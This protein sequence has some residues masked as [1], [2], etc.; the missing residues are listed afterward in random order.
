MIKL[1]ITGGIGSGKS[2]VSR[3]LQLMG[4]PVYFTDD[5]AKRLNV[6]SPVIRQGLRALVGEKVYCADGSLNRSLLAEYIFTD[7]HRLA[8][9][10]AIVHPEVKQDFL[11]WAERHRHCRVV[12]MECAIL[13]EAG[14]DTVVDEVAVVTAPLAL[15]VQRAMARDHASEE[16]ICRRVVHQMADEKWRA[17]QAHILLNDDNTPLIP[18]VIQLLEQ[19]SGA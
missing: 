11:C 8:Q 15:R 7:A 10:N 5:E 9:V 14:F 13:Y 6:E 1:A 3:L 19:I 17:Q 18:Q 2:V 16:Q 4:I 12:A